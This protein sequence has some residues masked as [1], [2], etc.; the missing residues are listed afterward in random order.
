MPAT[1]GVY[2]EVNLDTGVMTGYSITTGQLAWGPT[3]LPETDAYSSIGGYNY[4]SANG[5]CYLWGFGG[6]IYAVNMATGA[7]KWTVT[8]AQRLVPLGLTRLMVYGQYGLS[9]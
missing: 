3:N 9:R 1:A 7:I 4:V 8:T 6:T 5:Y 2:G